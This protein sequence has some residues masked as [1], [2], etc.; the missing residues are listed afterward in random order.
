[1]SF[2]LKPVACCAPSSQ[3]YIGGPPATITS[4]CPIHPP[5][6]SVFKTN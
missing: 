2:A 5:T 1:M 3:R 4:F 6:L